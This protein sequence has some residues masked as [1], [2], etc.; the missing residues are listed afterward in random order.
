MK[1]VGKVEEGEEGVVWDT[2]GV[3]VR[4]REKE[5]KIRESEEVVVHALVCARFGIVN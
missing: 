1:K 4:E 5:E 3:G 2:R